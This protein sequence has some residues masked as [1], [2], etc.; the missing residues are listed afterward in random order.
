[1]KVKHQDDA[2]FCWVCHRRFHGILPKEHSGTFYEV[3]WGPFKEMF[4][5]TQGQS[6][7]V[8]RPLLISE[9]KN[10]VTAANGLF[11]TIVK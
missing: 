5:N 6:D 11:S 8:T 10:I 7:I 3:P 4:T 2:S 1:M 9:M